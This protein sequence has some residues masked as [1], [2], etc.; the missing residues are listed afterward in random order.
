M[1]RRNVTLAGTFALMALALLVAN[2]YFD[3]NRTDKEKKGEK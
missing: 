2:V 3:K 1:N